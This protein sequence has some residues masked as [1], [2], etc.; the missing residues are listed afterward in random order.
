MS[1]TLRPL[2]T[3]DSLAAR[4]ER[5]M[6]YEASGTEPRHLFACPSFTPVLRRLVID[7]ALDA[8]LLRFWGR[9]GVRAK[10]FLGASWAEWN[11]TKRI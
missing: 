1:A 3:P 2:G 9:W 7:T 4:L 8:Q 11:L 5:E 10:C 6:P